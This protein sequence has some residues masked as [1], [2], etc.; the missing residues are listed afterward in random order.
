MYRVLTWAFGFA[1]HRFY[2]RKHLGGSVPDH[3]PVLLVAN[4]P[5]ALIDPAVVTQL[6]NRPICFLAFAPL[7]EMPVLGWIARSLHAVPVYR[8]KDGFDTKQNQDTF[9][10]VRQALLQKKVVCIFPEGKSHNEPELQPLK[11]GAARMV[12]ETEAETGFEL[13]VNVVPVGLT[14]SEKSRYRS[15]LATQIGI[16]ISSQPHRKTYRQ[17]AWSSVLQLTD[18]I[19]VGI[20][21]VTL[22]LQRWEDLPLLSLAEKVWQGNHQ[23]RFARLQA[24]AQGDRIFSQQ[25]PERLQGLR[26]RVSRFNERLNHLGMRVDHLDARYNILKVVWFILRNLLIVMIGLPLTLVGAGI[27]YLPYRLAG[28]MASRFRPPVEFIA[29]YKLLSALVLLLAWHFIFCISIGFLWSWPTAGLAFLILP[30]CG[31]ISPLFL[32]YAR[33]TWLETRVFL[34]APFTP[35]LRKRLR[36]E[37]DAIADRIND[38]AKREIAETQ[39]VDLPADQ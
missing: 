16:P 26:L 4:H 37:R 12:L 2:R 8:A 11:T 29:T 5:N 13:G 23:S 6:S 24:L 17:D 9:V 35:S 14:Y 21:Q 10:A 28:W 15:R 34:T 3:G 30:V 25:D 18:E 19:D 1:I 36:A 31:L 32:E 39:T 38:L 7:F 33:A 20:R 22:N 27:Y